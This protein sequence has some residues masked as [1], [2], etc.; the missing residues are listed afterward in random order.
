MPKKICLTFGLLAL[1]AVLFYAQQIS[2]A[3][4]FN[5]PPNEKTLINKKLAIKVTDG[6]KIRVPYE[7]EA[8][9]E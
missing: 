4:L 6:N 5:P 8:P 1:T 2:A 9:F 7:A 3:E